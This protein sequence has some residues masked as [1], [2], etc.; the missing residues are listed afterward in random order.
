M[1][2][3]CAVVNFDKNFGAGV[4]YQTLKFQIRQIYRNVELW[5]HATCLELKIGGK[6]TPYLG[7]D[8]LFFPKRIDSAW[9]RQNL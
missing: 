1:E 5:H 4:S 2:G 6:Y 8:G 7:T 9:L 3:H